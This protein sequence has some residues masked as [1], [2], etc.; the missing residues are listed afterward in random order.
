MTAYG[1]KQLG[2][3]AQAAVPLPFAVTVSALRVHAAPS[4]AG[5]CRPRS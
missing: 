1:D 5:W 4:R 2:T 3:A